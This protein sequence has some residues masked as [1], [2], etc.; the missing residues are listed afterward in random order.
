MT[1]PANLLRWLTSNKFEL[2]SRRFFL[3]YF[4]FSLTM[5][6]LVF[7]ISA[8]NERSLHLEGI[9]NDLGA[10]A[11]SIE[12]LG[13]LELPMR[14][15]P[16]IDTVPF[17][18]ARMPFPPYFL[19]DLDKISDGRFLLLHALKVYLLLLPL[20]LGA[21][22]LYKRAKHRQLILLVCLMLPF[23]IPDFLYLV[24]TL[25]IEEAYFYSFLILALALVLCSPAIKGSSAWLSM[26]AFAL[27]IDLIY[28]S[29]SS[30]RLTCAVLTVAWVIT[31]K[32]IARRIVVCLLFLLAP[33]GWALHCDTVSG[34]F[35]FGS[36]FDGFNLHKGNYAQFLDR[37]P[38]ADGGYMDKWDYSINPYHQFSSEWAY[39]DYHMALAKQFILYHPKIDAIAFLRKFDVFFLDLR[40]IGSGHRSD[41][42]SK[43]DPV[44]MLL[45]RLTL[46]SALLWS[47]LNLFIK[48]HRAASLLFLCVALSIAAPY[49]AGFAL[50]HQAFT[51]IFPSAMMLGYFYS[52]GEDDL[53]QTR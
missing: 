52:A 46:W 50:T 49:L 24:V 25:Q 48:R 3:G 21:W 34:R 53:T 35:T 4:G 1:T 6:T 27:S 42:L 12:I 5:I 45:F 36:S 18:C 39:N 41:L 23:L 51:L 28:L 16:F 8:R 11:R 37:Y 26:V 20:W 14:G 44:S 47:I 33:L 19:R 15:K 40:D 13:R 17:Y 9:T 31:D 29:K 43:V 2:S 32:S 10:T 30:M 7:C 22:L 38:P